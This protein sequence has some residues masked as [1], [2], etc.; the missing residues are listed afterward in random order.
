MSPSPCPYKRK[1]ALGS[2]RSRAARARAAQDIRDFVRIGC[3]PLLAGT[4][5]Q[6]ELARRLGLRIERTPCGGEADALRHLIDR[7]DSFC[8][9]LR[10]DRRWLRAQLAAARKTEGP[11]R[12]R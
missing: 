6:A 4:I 5:R 7:L 2:D 3:A 11:T 12:G 1:Y 9:F 10:T 8:R